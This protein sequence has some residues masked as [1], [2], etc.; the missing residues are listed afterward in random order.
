MPHDHAHS[1]GAA[2]VADLTPAF[3]LAVVLNAG[4]VLIE[5]GAGFWAGS[6]ALLAD[7]A[8]NLTDVA[9]LLIAWGAAALAK[10]AASH[11]YTWGYGRATLLAALGNG[12]AI[13]LGAGAVI[14][15]ALGRF[16]A[17]P[18]VPGL[19][20][21][22]VAAVGIAVNTG[23]A[24]LFLRHRA[25]LNARGAYLHMM[26]D[27]AVSLAV[28]LGAGLMLATGARWLDP[29][30]AIAVSLLIAVTAAQ[31]VADATRGLMDAVPEGRD[32]A[33]LAGFLALQ[34]GV[35]AVHDLHIWPIS[36]TRA[37]LSAHLC[38]PAGHPGDRFLAELAEELADHFAIAHATLQVETGPGPG[39]ATAS[40]C[41]VAT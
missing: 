2:Q 19:V 3:R 8:H 40:D 28:V 14:G 4:F 37:A 29:A 1:H 41:G 5:A 39:C 30:I 6:L 31:L 22:A 13:L 20:V 23:T 15:E 7:A 38:M 27:A 17:P 24:F 34:P 21:A 16:A 32:H 25:D 9:G 26:A 10:R 36:T 33:A 11:R 35:A 18:E 12:V